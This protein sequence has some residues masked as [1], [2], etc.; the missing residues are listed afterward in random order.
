MAVRTDLVG[1]LV[2]L[3]AALV[4]GQDTLKDIAS[5][6]TVAPVGKVPY[7]NKTKITVCVSDWTVSGLRASSFR[8]TLLLHGLKNLGFIFFA[9]LFYVTAWNKQ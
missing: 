6:P 4:V 7:F 5:V 2:L 3:Y 9:N 1:L 8:C